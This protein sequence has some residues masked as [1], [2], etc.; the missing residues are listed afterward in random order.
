MLVEVRDA[1]FVDA[2]EVEAAVLHLDTVRL[3]N[4]LLAAEDVAAEGGEVG[5][6][7]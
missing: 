1:L 4:F 7:G 6:D 2:E 3:V 5:G